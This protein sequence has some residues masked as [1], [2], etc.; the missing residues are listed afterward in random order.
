MTSYTLRLSLLDCNLYSRGCK[1]GWTGRAGIVDL[2]DGMF[3]RNFFSRHWHRQ[4]V[5]FFLNT[6]NVHRVLA[7]TKQQNLDSVEHHLAGAARSTA[8]LLTN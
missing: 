5:I 4:V 1:S 8:R 6:H 2:I 3:E 7:A